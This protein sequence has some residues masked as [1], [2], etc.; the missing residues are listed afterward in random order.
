MHIGWIYVFIFQRMGLQKHV[1]DEIVAAEAAVAD[2][3]VVCIV[4]TMGHVV[5]VVDEQFTEN[6]YTNLWGHLQRP[7][8]E[9]TQLSNYRR[10][11]H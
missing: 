3:V 1:Y 2:V 9:R 6:I 8:C 7:R 11:Y 10:H 4:T 5:F